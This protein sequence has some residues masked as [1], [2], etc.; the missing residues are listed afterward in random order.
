MVF[1]IVVEVLGDGR[2]IKKMKRMMGDN[3]FQKFIIF[4][5]K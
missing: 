5:I 3:I 1:S 2:R 4:K